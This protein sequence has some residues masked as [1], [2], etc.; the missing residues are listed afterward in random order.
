VRPCREPLCPWAAEVRGRCRD[1]AAAHS[2]AGHD[3]A[4]K[5]TY[6]SKRWRVAR[7]RQLRRHPLCQAD[8]CGA[9]AT[10]VDHRVALADGGAEFAQSN[11]QS[12]CHRHH[13]QK[14]SEEV[15][16]REW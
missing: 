6:N 8:G 4:R 11:L 10:D 7:D 15:R 1:H 16:E 2:R 9:V 14:T 13:S 12:L 5:A 3:P